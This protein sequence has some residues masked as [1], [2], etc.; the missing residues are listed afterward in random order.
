MARLAAGVI[1][2]F[3]VATVS[4]RSVIAVWASS[5]TGSSLRSTVEASADRVET[6]CV[7]LA[8]ASSNDLAAASSA[9]AAALTFFIALVASSTTPS[10]CAIFEIA[11]SRLANVEVRLRRF[12]S[13][14]IVLT[15]R[16]VSPET[17]SRSCPPARNSSTSVRLDGICGVSPLRDVSIGVAGSPGRIWMKVT[18]VM[19]CRLSCATLSVRTGV[20][21]PTRMCAITRLGSTRSSR[22]VVTSPTLMPLNLTSPPSDSPLTGPLK[23]T[24]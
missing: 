8:A 24:S 10:S 11:L 20:C 15:F 23:I 2:E 17:P 9:S 22:S 3:T 5:S 7:T 1:S 18:P 12:C 6:S 16:I 4:L 19:P 21:P 14:S 13:D